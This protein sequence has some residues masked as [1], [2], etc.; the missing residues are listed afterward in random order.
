MYLA[1]RRYDSLLP[2]RFLAP[3]D[4]LKISAQKMSRP[5]VLSLLAVLAGTVSADLPQIGRLRDTMIRNLFHT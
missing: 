2:P 5:V 3:I 4:S 1:G